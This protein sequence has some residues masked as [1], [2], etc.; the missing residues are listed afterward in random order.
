MYLGPKTKSNEVAVE[1]EELQIV[2]AMCEAEEFPDS[3]LDDDS[4]FFEPED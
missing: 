3:I 4:T 1:N 2:Q